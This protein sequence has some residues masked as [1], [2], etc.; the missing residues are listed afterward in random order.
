MKTDMTRKEIIKELSN[1]GYWNF[2]KSEPTENLY[3]MLHIYKTYYDKT[4]KFIGKTS[5]IE[6]IKVN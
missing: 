4:G 1:Y 2:E 5:L 6:H 3:S